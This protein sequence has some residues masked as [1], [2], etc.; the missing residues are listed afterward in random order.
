MSRFCFLLKFSCI[1][2][3]FGYFGNIMTTASLRTA[4]RQYE[5][6]TD[7]NSKRE[8]SRRSIFGEIDKTKEYAIC[9][10]CDSSIEVQNYRETL[11]TKLRGII[12]F[13]RHISN[14][15]DIK[16]MRSENIFLVLNFET[17]VKHIS[18][19]STFNQIRSIYVYQKCDDTIE[20]A[21]CVVDRSKACNET[22]I[23]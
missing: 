2:F 20:K 17:L 14:A 19:L 13:L 4:K 3:R 15:N 16:Q 6:N 11:K 7:C 22:I 9:W 23:V 10:F 1:F 5:E 12:D 21:E 18:Q 8:P